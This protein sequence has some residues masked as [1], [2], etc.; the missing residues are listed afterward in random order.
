MEQ[1]GYLPTYQ[2]KRNKMLKNLRQR[3]IWSPIDESDVAEE[4][5]SAGLGIL[6]EQEIND[7]LNEV[8]GY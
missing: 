5:A 4:A 2:G 3:A 8:S 6:T 1:E 7:I